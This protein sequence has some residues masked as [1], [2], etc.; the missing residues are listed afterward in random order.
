MSN[1]LSFLRENVAVLRRHRLKL[2]NFIITSCDS[3]GEN[4]NLYENLVP[5]SEIAEKTNEITN[6]NLVDIV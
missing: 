1:P 3:D 4:S 6:D 5:T 2:F